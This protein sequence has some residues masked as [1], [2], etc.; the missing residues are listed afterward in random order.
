MVW[1]E[2]DFGRPIA[3]GQQRFRDQGEIRECRRLVRGQAGR[4]VFVQVSHFGLFDLCWEFAASSVCDRREPGWVVSVG[5]PEQ[6][7]V[8]MRE[9]AFEGFLV[10]WRATALRRK[11]EVENLQFQI[12]KLHLDALRLEDLVA[13]LWD[14]SKLDT[15][16][17]DE[18]QSSTRFVVGVILSDEVVAR[19]KIRRLAFAR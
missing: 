10:N 15:F 7:G 3:R 4:A 6:Q 13:V 19:S 1:S 14:F 8:L 11:V 17:D 18:N 12:A 16:M 2:T 9:Q 5:I